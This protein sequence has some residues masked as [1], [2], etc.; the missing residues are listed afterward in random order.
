MPATLDYPALSLPPRIRD[1]A[2]SQIGLV[3]DLGRDDP[4]VVKLWIGE[5]DLPTPP[6][7]IDA[8]TAA[9]KAGHTRYTYSVGLPALRRSLSAY[10]QRHWGVNLPPERFAV[11][12]GGMN[13]IMQACQAILRGSS[14]R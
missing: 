13:A 2:S 14:C 7:V 4:D 10:H 11:T 9:M 6:F 5:G 8:A 3:A 1:L 12:S